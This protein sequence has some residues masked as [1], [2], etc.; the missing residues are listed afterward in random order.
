[1]YK[2]YYAQLTSDERRFFH[3]CEIGNRSAVEQYLVQQPSDVVDKTDALGR[4]PL[5]IAVTQEYEEIVVVLLEY[6]TESVY[7]ALLKAISRNHV[8]I[9]EL[10]ITHEH[11]KKFVLFLKYF[12]HS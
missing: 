9:A 2:K 5:T 12:V 10:I 8:D 1:M 11:Y 7:D 6:T 3:Y 4:T